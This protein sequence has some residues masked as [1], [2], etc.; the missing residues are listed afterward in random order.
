MQQRWDLIMIDEAHKCSAYTKHRS[1]RPD[2]V[3]K[4]KRYHG[5]SD[6]AIPLVKSTA[7]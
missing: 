3:E 7:G 2:E 4:T 1:G 6:G 5:L